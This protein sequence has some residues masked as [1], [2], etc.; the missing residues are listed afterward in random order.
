MAHQTTGYL[1]HPPLL[2]LKTLFVSVHHL[3]HMDCLIRNFAY[4][5]SEQFFLRVPSFPLTVYYHFLKQT[6]YPP[7][8]LVPQTVHLDPA[9][10][11][12]L[13]WI[14]QIKILPVFHFHFQYTIHQFQHFPEC[15]LYKQKESIH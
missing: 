4:Q 2:R 14:H 6:R 12:Q 7:L 11:F 9:K 8:H 15:L 1:H 5:Q 10:P 3:I 13:S